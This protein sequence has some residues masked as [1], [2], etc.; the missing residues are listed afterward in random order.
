MFNVH[1]HHRSCCCWLTTT[2]MLKSTPSSSTTSW[3]LVSQ[4]NQ[5]FLDLAMVPRS[6]EGSPQRPLVNNVLTSVKGQSS[7]L[8]VWLRDPALKLGPTKPQQGPQVMPTQVVVLPGVVVVAHKSQPQVVA[9][10]VPAGRLFQLLSNHH[11]FSTV[12]FL[13]KCLV[14]GFCLHLVLANKVNLSTAIFLV[15]F[16]VAKSNQHLVNQTLV[17]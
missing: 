6:R 14:V 9:G 13:S 15:L 1:Q 17:I 10:K 4:T 2:W 8:L 5:G 3:G 7:G 16:L 11:K 12:M